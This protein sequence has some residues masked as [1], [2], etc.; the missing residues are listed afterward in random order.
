MVDFWAVSAQGGAARQRRYVWS[1]TVAQ[2]APVKTGPDCSPL[3]N[4]GPFRRH[5]CRAGTQLTG[6]LT[7]ALSVD[8]RL[9]LAMPVTANHPPRSW[10]PRPVRPVERWSTTSPD[11]PRTPLQPADST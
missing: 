8:R 10:S 1:C 5:L 3:L 2:A 7:Q 6:T 9:L 4:P 11:V